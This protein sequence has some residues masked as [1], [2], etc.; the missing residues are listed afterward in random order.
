[1]IRSLKSCVYLGVSI[2]TLLFSGHARSLESPDYIKLARSGLEKI[3][4]MDLDQ[5]WFFTVTSHID[6]EILISR[7]NPFNED[8]ERRELLSV[9]G[10]AP[11]AERLEEFKKRELARNEDRDEQT[12]EMQFSEL[13]DLSTLKLMEISDRQ[14]RLSFTPDLD[15]F[16]KDKD[17]LNGTLSLNADTHLIEDLTLFNNGKISPAFSVS[18]KTFRMNLSFTPID[19]ELLLTRMAST[20]EGKVGFLKKFNSNSEIV[21]S[22][23]R[24]KPASGNSVSP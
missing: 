22:D 2:V 11:T 16:E 18:I 24:R 8:G 6:D 19:G 12:V 13:V 5:D 21:F 3:D 14:V 23:Y 10:E 9:N 20:V 4:A 15:E 1:M 7:N 17:K